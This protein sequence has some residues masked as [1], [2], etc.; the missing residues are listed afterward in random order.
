M[1]TIALWCLQRW[2]AAGA[3]TDYQTALRLKPGFSAAHNNLG[4]LRRRAAK[5][6]ASAD[7]SFAAAAD[8][9]RSSDA[10]YNRALTA[11]QRGD[12]ALAQT[13]LRRCIK[14]ARRDGARAAL[15]DVLTDLGE[16]A[17]AL[18]L[19]RAVP[20]THSGFVAT[21]QRAGAGGRPPATRCGRALRAGLLADPGNATLA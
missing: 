5:S 1:H 15:V 21:V 2:G 12:L 6:L 4:V 20:R 16:R 11:F 17:E 9:S 3:M 14:R 19:A 10:R 18:T 7:A 8:R 13:L